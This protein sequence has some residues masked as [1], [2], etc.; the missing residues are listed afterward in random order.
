M[1]HLLDDVIDL[2]AP[3]E[4]CHVQ[5]LPGMPTLEA[6]KLTILRE[7]DAGAAR[8]FAARCARLEA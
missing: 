2:L 3:P 5:V 1:A 8:G 6:Q 7:F 4:S